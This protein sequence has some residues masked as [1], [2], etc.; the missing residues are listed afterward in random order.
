MFVAFGISEDEYMDGLILSLSKPTKK[1]QKIPFLIFDNLRMVP[2][3]I[4][5][6]GGTKFKTEPINLRNALYGR[7]Y[8]H[9]FQHRIR[10]FEELT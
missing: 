7:D 10:I 9:F 6:I 2:S 3:N 5:N 1:L 4:Q 8:V